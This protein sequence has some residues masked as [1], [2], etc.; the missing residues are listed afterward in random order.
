MDG[1]G[2][3]L[4][5][6]NVVKGL[7]VLPLASILADPVL[8][9]QAAAGLEEVEI[10]TEGGRKAHGALAIPA[11]LPAPAI[12]T[13]HEWWGLNDQIKATTAEYAKEGY[14]A[15][16][17]DLYGGE[18][19][20]TRKRASELTRAMDAEAGKDIV[21]GWAEW[22]RGHRDCSGSVGTVGWCFGGG[23]SLQTAITVPVDA[24]VVYYGRCDLP[25]EQL[26]RLDGPVMGH[27]GTRDTFI[28]EDMVARFAAAMNEA[29]KSYIIHWYDADHA[30]ANPTGARYDEADAQLA[31]SRTLNFFGD[32]LR[33]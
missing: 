26:A 22:L 3:T 23:W 8:A 20:T 29:A 27:F 11:K 5:R 33:D 30:F 14:L 21:A 4:S 9:A 31:W 24:C 19:A 12:I 28:N 25:A 1:P 10:T 17:L 6:R 16:A 15:L 2:S 13:I 18:V 32:H 7:G